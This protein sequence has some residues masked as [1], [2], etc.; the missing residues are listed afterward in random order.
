[1]IKQKKHTIKKHE[2]HAISK[3]KKREHHHIIHKLHKKHKI[4]YKTLFY[5]KE[6]G[7]KSHVSTVIIRESIKMLIL[8]SVISSIGGLHIKNVE[9]T[10]VRALPLLIM[11]P[12]LTGM[13]GGFGTVA[14]SKFT[15]MLFT[16]KIRS[17]WWK[18]RDFI[19]V[20]HT[21]FAVAFLSS[22]YMSLFA[23]FVAVTKGF[24]FSWVLVAKTL[25]LAM[26]ATMSLTMIVLLVSV[27]FGVWIYKKH[28]DPNNFLIPIAT[29]VADFFS[30]FILAFLAVAFF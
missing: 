13:I 19:E 5:M 10:L 24:A 14:S 23:Y 25:L 8:A 11:L 12:A 29:S 27:V 1:M 9:T 16:G 18:S 6:Y 21:M 17:K 4:S 7:P 15:T 30:M 3:I 22:I 28:E 2:I 26:I 20:V